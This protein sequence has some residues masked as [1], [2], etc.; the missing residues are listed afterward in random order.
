MTTLTPAKPIVRAQALIAAM[1][2]RTDEL[3]DRA[4]EVIVRDVLKLEVVETPVAPGT[5]PRHHRVD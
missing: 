3:L 5:G 2:H 1:L 4:A